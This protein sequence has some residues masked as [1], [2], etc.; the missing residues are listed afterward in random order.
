VP[1]SWNT[2]DYD[3][4]DTDQEEMKLGSV[5]FR[6]FDLGGHKGARTLWRDYLIDVGTSRLSL[7]P[8]PCS[9]ATRASQTLTGAPWP[10]PPDVIV[11]LVD[12]SKRSRF[13]EAYAELNSILKNDALAQ[14]PVLVLG[15]KID[16]YAHVIVVPY[17]CRGR[18]SA[19]LGLGIS[20][21]DDRL[22]FSR[23]EDRRAEDVHGNINSGY[24]GRR[25]RES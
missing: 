23:G 5:T 3:V 16:R 25:L 8:F 24:P 12:A 1:C 18:G 14:V 11:F 17:H 22:S 4:S 9:H 15:N 21:E 7:S 19:L 6:T 20:R 2:Y 10:L 13:E